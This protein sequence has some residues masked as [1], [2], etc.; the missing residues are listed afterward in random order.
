MLLPYFTKSFKKNLKQVL[1]R[2]KSD[3]SQI[4]FVITE[5]IKENALDYKHKPHELIGNYAGIMECHIKSD[6]LLLYIY[7]ENKVVFTQ[8]GSHLDLFKK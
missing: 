7:K 4:G 5:I 8:I 1:K 3:S 6:L 2:R